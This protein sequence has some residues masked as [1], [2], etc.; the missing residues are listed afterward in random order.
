ML[1]GYAHPY[2]RFTRETS[3]GRQIPYIVTGA[4]GYAATAP[5]P[6]LTP[7][8]TWGQYTLVAQPIVAYGYLT[9]TVDLA[10]RTLTFAYHP[11]D[12]SIAGD[13]VTV[14]LEA[15]TLR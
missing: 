14:D 7:P 9:A 5:R 8:E 11:S 13:Q 15:H 4:G 2:E 3:D 12:S 6:G 10:A 1:S